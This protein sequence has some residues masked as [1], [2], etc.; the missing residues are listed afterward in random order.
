MITIL[1][2]TKAE[3]VTLGNIK[4][5]KSSHNPKAPNLVL[6]KLEQ[7]QSTI[8]AKTRNDVYSYLNSRNNYIKGVA[9]LEVD[10]SDIKQVDIAFYYEN[11]VFPAL[12]E[13]KRQ[14]GTL[15]L[16]EVM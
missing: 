2:P 12:Q 6:I 7:E 15:N 14:K 3:Q 1:K 4:T 16:A 5:L 9:L 13:Q 11:Y 8:I 10:G